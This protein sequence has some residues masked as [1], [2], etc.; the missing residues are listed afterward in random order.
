VEAAGGKSQ[1]GGLAAAAGVLALAAF[2]AGLLAN[3]PNAALAGVLFFV[4]RRI[5]RVAEFAH[6]ARRTPAEF[7]LAGATMLLIVLLPIQTGVA[8]GVFLSLAHGVFTITRSRVIGFE[9]VADTTVWWPTPDAPPTPHDG[10]LVVGFQAPL[11]F[12]NAYEFRRGLRAALAARGGARLI[13]L[14][15]SSIV[16]IDFTASDILIEVIR[17]ARR[18]GV[19]FAIARLESVRAQTAL[20]RFG[21][22]DALG[23]GRVFHSVHEAIAALG[24]GAPSPASDGD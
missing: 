5:F 8:I 13:V 16:E 1:V 24:R 12:L 9:P 7:A 19:L 4:A 15:A 21:V 3:V 22:I 2:G 17:A 10:V 11:S 14:E 6:L 20:S 23:S 18:A